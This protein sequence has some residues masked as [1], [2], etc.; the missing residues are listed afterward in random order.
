MMNALLVSLLSVSCVSNP[1]A[2]RLEV[3]RERL[4]QIV[5]DF[6]AFFKENKAPEFQ[7]SDVEF[8]AVVLGDDGKDYYYFDFAGDNGYLLLSGDAKALRFC[9]FGDSKEIRVAQKLSFDGDDIFTDGV[10]ASFLTPKDCAIEVRDPGAIGGQ[11]SDPVEYNGLSSY[12]A[13][14]YSFASFSAVESGKLPGMSTGVNSWGYGQYAESVYVK[15]ENGTSWSEGNC[16]VVSMANC[17]NYLSRY[18]GLS[19]LTNADAFTT[20]NPM[21]ELSVYASAIS[22]GYTPKASPIQIHSLYAA[23]RSNAIQAGY[24]V[25][26]MNDPM[27]EYAFEETA[28]DFGYVGS[29]TAYNSPTVS[30]I[31]GEINAG[32]PVQLRV[33]NDACYGDHGL[34]VTGYALQ[35]AT[36]NIG[37]LIA[38]FDIFWV[39]VFDGWSN[40]ERWYDMTSLSNVGAIYSRADAQTIATLSVT[41]L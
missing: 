20:I 15:N 1:H 41:A 34:I 35:E 5:F 16:G 30:Q 7:T 37:G 18:S 33:G 26:G 10:K 12:I 40:S 2:A 9:P 25:G 22:Q 28:A 36:K 14:K 31:Q 6:N 17:F 32:R 29:F 39:S 23:V 19:G 13:S 11:F 21:F 38:V 24:T 4:D 8:D 3:Y 27:T